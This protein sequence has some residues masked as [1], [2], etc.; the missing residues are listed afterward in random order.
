MSLG[1]IPSRAHSTNGRGPVM[2]E[3]R[4]RRRIRQAVESRGFKVD[5]LDWEP[6]YNAGEMEGIGGGWSLFLDRNCFENTHPGNDLHA[7]SVDEMLGYIDW[8][9]VPPEP[10][11][12][13]PDGKRPW[14]LPIHPLKGDPNE[15]LHAESC[16]WRLS[17]RLSWWP[18]PG[19]PS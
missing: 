3:T 18:K 11:A 4:A 8:A 6:W 13:Y 7:L 14:R 5:S 19:D 12:C 2:P 1:R 15:P 10:C 16:P 9:L 17:Y